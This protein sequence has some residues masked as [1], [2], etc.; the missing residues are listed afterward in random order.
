MEHLS[1]DRGRE[2]VRRFADAEIWKAR[3]ST[4]WEADFSSVRSTPL[5][6]HHFWKRAPRET[7]GLYF[8][9]DTPVP[10]MA[11]VGIETAREARRAG[12]RERCESAANAGTRSARAGSQ[13]WQG[14]RIESDFHERPTRCQRVASVVPP[15]FTPSTLPSLAPLPSSTFLYTSSGLPPSIRPL[16]CASLALNLPLRAAS[17]NP[18]SS[19]ISYSVV[20]LLY[21]LRSLEIPP[22]SPSICFSLPGPDIRKYRRD[23]R[24]NLHGFRWPSLFPEW[25]LTVTSIIDTSP[26]LSYRFLKILCILKQ[27]VSQSPRSYELN[28]SNP[29]RKIKPFINAS[30]LT[31]SPTVFMFSKK[32]KCMYVYLYYLIIRDEV[33]RYRVIRLRRGEFTSLS[34]V[35]RSPTRFLRAQQISGITCTRVPSQRTRCAIITWRNAFAP[36][37]LVYLLFLGCELKKRRSFLR[38]WQL[39]ATRSF[40]SHRDCIGNETPAKRNLHNVTYF[41]VYSSAWKTTNNTLCGLQYIIIRFY[42]A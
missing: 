41:R 6:L 19:A 5:R 31:L 40:L 32:T 30:R 36:P 21:I 25:L 14:E 24:H 26:V 1:R 13:F 42:W 28:F 2:S 27:T 3:H 18:D 8:Q 22:H 17:R 29:N 10:A 33:A 20:C 37:I 15:C 35:G 11:T 7:L 16:A 38:F 34:H 9:R 39:S 12:P 23:T 4:G